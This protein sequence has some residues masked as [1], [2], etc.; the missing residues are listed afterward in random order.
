MDRIALILKYDRLALFLYLHNFQVNDCR[1]DGTI[2][3][4]II[5][6]QIHTV[7]TCAIVLHTRNVRLQ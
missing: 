4:E 3:G 7:W 1:C 5:R 6:V 2:V